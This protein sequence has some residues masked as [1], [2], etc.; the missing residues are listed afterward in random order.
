MGFIVGLGDRHTENILVD[1]TSGECI[2]VDFDCLFDKGLG[3]KRPEIVPFRLTPNIV[4]IYPPTPTP[5]LLA[6]YYLRVIVFV[7]YNCVGGCDGFD[8]FRRHI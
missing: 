7:L 2:H 5:G 4:S 3:L 6:T 1:V 8:R